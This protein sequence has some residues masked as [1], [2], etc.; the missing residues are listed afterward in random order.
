MRLVEFRCG[1]ASIVTSHRFCGSGAQA[2]DGTRH[3]CDARSGPPPVSRRRR[4]SA[5]HNLWRT[6]CINAQV[7]RRHVVGQGSRQMATG[8][9]MRLMRGYGTA[10][11]A[12]PDMTCSAQC[13]QR[14]SAATVSSLRSASPAAL[15]RPIAP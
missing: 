4:R 6:L 3:T 8:A 5:V 10:S 14:A 11:G 13:R 1:T 7:N 9:A 15:S 12:G 2:A